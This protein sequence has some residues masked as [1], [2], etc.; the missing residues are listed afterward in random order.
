LVGR[1]GWLQVVRVRL[2]RRITHRY[3][4]CMTQLVTRIDEHLASLIDE[5]IA[6]GV[7]ES[8][9]DAVRQGLATLID[10]HHRCRTAEAIIRGYRDLPQS[11]QEVGWA[12]E[13]TVRMIGEEPW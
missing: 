10:R 9:S 3:A 6:E 8:R 7:V 4:V 2:L 1:P 13:A 11:E 5:L 12:D